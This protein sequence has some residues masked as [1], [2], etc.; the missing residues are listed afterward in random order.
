MEWGDEDAVL[1]S[2]VNE[3]SGK[4]TANKIFSFSI[5]NYSL[6]IGI[7]YFIVRIPSTHL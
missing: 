6:L 2:T 4:S 7:M 5:L 3:T 1:A